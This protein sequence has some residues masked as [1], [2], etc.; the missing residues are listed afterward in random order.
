MEM[1]LTPI[2]SSITNSQ[3]ALSS[4]Q[5]IEFF[6]GRGTLAWGGGGESQFPPCVYVYVIMVYLCY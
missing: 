4:G 2:E 3:A 1:A 6:G 5:S